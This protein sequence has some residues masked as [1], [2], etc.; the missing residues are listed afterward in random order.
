MKQF[1][2]VTVEKA[3]SRLKLEKELGATIGAGDTKDFVS[4]TS[5][6]SEAIA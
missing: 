3:M 2:I 1:T 6:S 4:G 5:E